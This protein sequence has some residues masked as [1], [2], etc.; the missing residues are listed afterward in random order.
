MSAGRLERLLGHRLWTIPALGLVS[1]F[2][3]SGVTVAIDRQV[4][5][6]MLPHSVVGNAADAQ[7]ICTRLPP[8]SSR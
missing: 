4:H 5:P 3:L 2:V 8:R 1:G 6:H 7:A